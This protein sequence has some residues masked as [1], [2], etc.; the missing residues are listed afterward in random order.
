MEQKRIEYFQSKLKIDKHSL[1]QALEEQAEIYYQISE[2][3]ALAISHRDEAYENI[4]LVDAEL[5]S[6]LRREFEEEGKKV[7]ESV[8][9]SAVLQHNDHSSAVNNHLTCKLYADQLAALKDSFH[10]RSYMLRELVELYISGYYAEKTYSTTEEK[11][12]DISY[13]KNKDE[14]SRQRKERK[15]LHKNVPTH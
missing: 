15:K 10:Q 12:S 8:V 9:S 11:Q 3:H 2:E 1:D 7:T 14:L 13:R 4:K 5:N 6:S